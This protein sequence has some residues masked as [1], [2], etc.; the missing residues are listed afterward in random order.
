MTRIIIPVENQNGLEATVAR[1]FGQAPYY[2]LVEIDSKGETAKIEASPNTGEHM[3]G[4]GHPHENLHSLKPDV[5]AAYG[6]GQGG[7]Q[8]F[9]SAGTRVLKAEGNT[10]REVVANFKKGILKELTGG[11]EHAHHHDHHHIHH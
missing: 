5:I 9:K 3:G 7:L 8:S 6:M 2:T 1:H 4:T 10:V 11:C